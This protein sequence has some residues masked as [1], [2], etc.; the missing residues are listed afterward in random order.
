MKKVYYTIFGI[1]TTIAMIYVLIH[2]IVDYCYNK[3]P[4]EFFKSKICRVVKCNV[5][6]NKK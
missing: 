1:I 6:S 2:L 3:P 4:N 5:Y